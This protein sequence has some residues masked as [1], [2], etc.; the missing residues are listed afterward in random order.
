MRNNIHPDAVAEAIKTLMHALI[1][2]ECTIKM[3]KQHITCESEYVWEAIPNTLLYVQ[4]S[5]SEALDKAR[6]IL[7]ADI[8]EVRS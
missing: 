6:K 8:Q 3:V 2:I 1:D 5:A 4:L 7:T